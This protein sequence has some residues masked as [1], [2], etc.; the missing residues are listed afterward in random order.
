MIWAKQKQGEKQTP[1]RLTG[2][3]GGKKANAFLRLR[4]RKGLSGQPAG[5]K[6]FNALTVVQ[7]ILCS[8]G[9]SMLNKDW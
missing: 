9:E 1:D 6:M 5:L 2:L 8:G 4:G 3:P 7:A